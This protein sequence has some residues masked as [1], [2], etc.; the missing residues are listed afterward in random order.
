MA[1]EA[2]ALAATTSAPAYVLQALLFASGAVWM[3]WARARI[4]TRG[5]AWFASRMVVVVLTTVVGMII[6]PPTSR[7]QSSDI[8]S[9]V[10]NPS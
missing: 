7:G 10:L 9:T 1:I 3:T 8:N 4:S 5:A 2:M 6:N